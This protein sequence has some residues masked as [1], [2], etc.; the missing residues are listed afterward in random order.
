LKKILFL[1]PLWPS[2]GVFQGIKN[3][4]RFINTG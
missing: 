4:I 2:K 3:F 1:F